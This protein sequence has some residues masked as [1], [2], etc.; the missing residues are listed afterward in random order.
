MVFND[1]RFVIVERE[2]LDK[3]MK[4]MS[5]QQTG[6]MDSEIAL[7]VGKLTGAKVI[8][9]IK[10]NSNYILRMVSV[11]SGQVL[12]YNYIPIGDSGLVS[13]KKDKA[14]DD[15][16]SHGGKDIKE[17]HGGDAAFRQTFEAEKMP[18][19]DRYDVINTGGAIAVA[20]KENI[21]NH[22]L[23]GPYVRLPHEGRYKLTLYMMFNYPGKSYTFDVVSGV[24]QKKEKIHGRMVL[25]SNKYRLKSWVAVPMI[26][27]YDGEGDLEFRLN[28]GYPVKNECYV[29]KFIIEKIG[30]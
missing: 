21:N 9:F 24:A 23:Y 13:E 20:P 3:I 28:S 22:F 26:V 16:E 2:M 25:H 19:R 5:L 27:E 18:G 10:K 11:E 29:D 12:A 30:R 17:K 4:E 7:R 14:I 8:L 15:S 6:L 1:G